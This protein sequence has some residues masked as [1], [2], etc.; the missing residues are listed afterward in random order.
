MTDERWQATL[1]Q[2][3]VAGVVDEEVDVTT[4]FTNEYLPGA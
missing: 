1:E 2:L 3:T 4:A